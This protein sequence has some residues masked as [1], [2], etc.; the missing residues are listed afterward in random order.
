[1]EGDGGGGG[2]FMLTLTGLATIGG[3]LFGYDTGVVSG[4][5][6]LMKEEF[7]LDSVWQEMIVSITVGGAAAFAMIGGWAT[8]HFGRKKVIMASSLLFTLGSLLLAAAN[9]RGLLL[10]GR[11][12]VG[13]AIGLSSMTVPMY[14]VEAAPQKQRGRL[15]TLQNLAIT[16]GQ[17]FAALIDGGFSYVTGGWRWMMGLAVVPATLQFLGFFAMP[18]SPRWLI[19]RGRLEEARRILYRT[20]PSKAEAD[21]EVDAVQSAYQEVEKE[22]AAKGIRGPVILSMLRSSK[23]RKALF[24]GCALQLFQ[25]VTGINTIM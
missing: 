13:C 3:F 2:V 9:G 20:R 18:E 16:F 7:N 10:T 8:E 15:V 14:I 1:M 5:M 21:A 24:V 11:L 4:A 22:K 6:I 25:Q 19:E 23:L 17:F 12:I